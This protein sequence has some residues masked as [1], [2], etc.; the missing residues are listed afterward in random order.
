MKQLPNTKAIAY[1][2]TTFHRSI[3][4]HIH[5]LAFD[6]KLCKEYK[7]RKYGFH[8]ISYSFMLRNV[9]DYL[10]KVRFSSLPSMYN[11]T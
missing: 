1:F 5:T 3:P 9:A 2:D 10:K 4:A 11:L 7:L 6:Q 8:G